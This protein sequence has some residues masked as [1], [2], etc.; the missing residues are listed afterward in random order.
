M[1]ELDKL[2]IYE[3]HTMYYEYF[4]EREAESKLSKEEQAANA[5]GRIIEDNTEKQR[6]V[7]PDE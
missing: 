6:R 5:M 7:F 3:V 4:R 1:F 2:P